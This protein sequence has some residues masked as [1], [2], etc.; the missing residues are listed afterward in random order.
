MRRVGMHV[1]MHFQG[2]LLGGAPYAFSP[3]RPPPRSRVRAPP[4][5]VPTPQV[6]DVAAVRAALEQR[7]K[8]LESELHQV[9]RLQ[10]KFAMI[11]STLA[12]QQTSAKHDPDTPKLRQSEENPLNMSMR[13]S[14]P[15][16][17]AGVKVRALATQPPCEQ[18][19]LGVV[20]CGA[21]GAGRA[22]DAHASPPTHT[23]AQASQEAAA[24]KGAARG[25]LTSLR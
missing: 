13:A 25:V 16:G 3:A 19:G 5:L 14:L 23:A 21:C 8:S 12:Q 2:C 10:R 7:L 18:A 9:E 22:C 1:C 15:G 4:A 17:A 20:S 6:F 24:K 11:H